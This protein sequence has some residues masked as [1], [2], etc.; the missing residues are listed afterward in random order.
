[1]KMQLICLTNYVYVFSRSVPENVFQRKPEQLDPQTASELK[2]AKRNM[3]YLNIKVE[4][5]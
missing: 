1:M 4:V 5:S 2:N 3:N